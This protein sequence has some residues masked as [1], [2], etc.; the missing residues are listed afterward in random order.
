MLWHASSMMFLSVRPAPHF[1]ISIYLADKDQK[2]MADNEIAHDR[3]QHA[4]CNIFC[5]LRF[6]IVG[7]VQYD[8]FQ[9]GRHLCNTACQSA[10]YEFVIYPKM[11]GIR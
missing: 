2:G 11:S 1:S 9:A 10:L 5:Y 6:K 4:S 8:V 3:F 7:K